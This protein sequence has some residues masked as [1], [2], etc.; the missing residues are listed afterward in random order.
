MQTEFIDPID[1]RRSL[2][3]E[4]HRADFDEWLVNYKRDTLDF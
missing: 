2:T 1:R 4:G 3:L